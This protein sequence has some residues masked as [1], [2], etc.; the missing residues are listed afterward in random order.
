MSIPPHLYFSKKR[1]NRH[2]FPQYIPSY[3]ELSLWSILCL[4][5]N[6]AVYIFLQVMRFKKIR[7]YLTIYHTPWYH[8]LERHTGSQ[9]ENRDKI[10]PSKPTRKSSRQNMVVMN[11]NYFYKT[12]PKVQKRYSYKILRWVP[13]SKVEITILHTKKSSISLISGLK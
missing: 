13:C 5:V 12:R 7:N 11:L 3:Q 10:T 1:L 9:L 4:R 2:L 8:C 6:L